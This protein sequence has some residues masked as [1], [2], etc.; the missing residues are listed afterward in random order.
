MKAVLLAGG[1]GTRL[2]EE[3]NSRPKPMVEIGGKPILWHI[4]KMYSFHGINDFIICCGYKGYMIK[5]YFANYFLHQSDVTFSLEDN[6]MNVHERR[7]EPWNVTL[8]DTGLNSMTGGRLGR[9]KEYIKDEE[10]FCFTYGDGVGD[11]D[12]SSL[13]NFHKQHGKQATVTTSYPPGRFGALDITDGQVTNFNEKPKGDG[14]MING[15][16][17]G[18][19]PKVLER[20][21]GDKCVW[22][23]Q[24]LM[25]LA[26]NKQLMAYE[27]QG[28]W[29]P[30]D[31][32]RDKVHLENLW[33]NNQAPWKI[34][35]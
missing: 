21:T 27:H 10:S 5:E 35:E 12:I 15:G 20:I 14:A 1:L 11:I 8:V 22:E 34:W 16:F 3:T 19:S 9:V 28:F 32:L 7:V 31:T 29:Q 25:S 2:S 26:E 6:K 4:M 33:N 23:Q 18:L 17:C 30:M 13:I 24:P